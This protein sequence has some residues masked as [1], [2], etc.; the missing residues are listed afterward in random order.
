[1]AHVDPTGSDAHAAQA[2]ASALAEFARVIAALRAPD[3]CPWDREQ[4]HASL[5]K[6]LIEE[7][8]ETVHAIG[9]G[10]SEDLADELGDVLLQVVL[11][12]QIAAE[13]GDFTLA[14]VI[15][16][17][18]RKIVRRHPHVFGTAVADTPDEVM[19]T[20]DEVKR[21]ERHAAAEAAGHGSA[22][23]VL[24]GVTPALPALA[25]AQKISR[26]A[27]AA[28]FEWDDIDGVWDKV[29]EEIAE[30]REAGPGT[31]EAT[32]ELGDLLF[33]VVNV[34]RHLGIDAEDA[35]RGTCT[36][37]VRRIESMERQAA[38]RQTDVRRLSA[39]EYERLWE[40]AKDEEAAGGG[41]DEGRE[42]T[43]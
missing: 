15:E 5:A 18:T 4:T 19:A 2:A 23:G 30:L 37:F 25:Y 6:H 27:A 34:A 21:G 43:P 38:A 20:W 39:A 24:A 29:H 10:S 40:H 12:A 17:I 31:P 26:R 11:H 9:T 7:A 14:E 8:Y 33:T 1:M 22:P 42:Q 35:L 36:K 3:G 13:A 28:G 41:R 32:D 16:G